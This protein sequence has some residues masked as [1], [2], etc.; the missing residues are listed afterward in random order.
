MGIGV[1]PNDQ[2]GYLQHQAMNNDNS[3]WHLWQQVQV[4]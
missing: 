1:V 3:V 2:V 4:G